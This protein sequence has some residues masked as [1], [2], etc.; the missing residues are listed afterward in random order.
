[1]GRLDGKVA[2]V[3]GAGMGQGRAT[4]LRLAREGAR[5]IATDISGAEKDTA[6]E[7]PGSIHAF[8]A[9]VTRSDDVEALVREATT[10][11]GRLDVMC[12]VVGLSVGIAQ[13]FVPDIDEAQ[14][15]R[16]IAV[17]LKS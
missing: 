5:V 1:M 8:Q 14:W 2:I 9:D 6:A 3:T 13:G 17:N 11:H 10:R 4:A 7:M 16:L 12:N 15:D